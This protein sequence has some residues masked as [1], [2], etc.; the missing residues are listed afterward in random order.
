MSYNFITFVNQYGEAD[1]IRDYLAATVNID[2]F[3]RRD[4]ARGWT[5]PNGVE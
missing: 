5:I 2:E 1:T 4:G 3:P